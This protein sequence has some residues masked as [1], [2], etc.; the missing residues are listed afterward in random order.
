[1]SQVVQ[2]SIGPVQPE[3]T[4]KRT[5]QE[6][7]AGMQH[8]HPT[9]DCCAG[10]SALPPSQQNG[11]SSAPTAAEDDLVAALAQEAAKAQRRGRADPFANMD[12]RFKEVRL[13]G[14]RTLPAV[15]RCIFADASEAAG[16][17]AM[18][19][20]LPAA[21]MLHHQGCC[22]RMNRYQ[23]SEAHAVV[24][25]NQQQ[26]THMNAAARAD[27]NAARTAFGADYEQR[28]RSE[29]GSAPD[30]LSR[31]KHQISSLYHQAKIKVAFCSD[32]Q[33]S[34]CS[35]LSALQ[36]YQRVRSSIQKRAA[37]AGA[38]DAGDKDTGPQDQGRDSCQ[39]WLVAGLGLIPAL[40]QSPL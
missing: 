26:L 40:K 39:V 1:M 27:A 6:A 14:A 22:C 2:H 3:P 13:P 33:L 35:V 24:Q 29:A 36:V 21:H 4:D 32:G 20:F 31:R 12:L 5:P 9:A 38:G 15:R 19:M 28:L 7:A 10:P 17:S 34:P 18:N 37:C 8:S 11:A 25:V 23:S 16:L 30:K